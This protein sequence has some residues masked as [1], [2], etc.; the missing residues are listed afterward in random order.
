MNKIRKPRR[1]RANVKET[2]RDKFASAALTG[3]LMRGAHDHDKREGNRYY[4][5]AYEIADGMLEARKK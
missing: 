1:N 4:E 5:L 2:L 3:L